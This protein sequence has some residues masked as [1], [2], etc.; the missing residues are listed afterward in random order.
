M[1]IILLSTA[2]TL[3]LLTSLQDVNEGRRNL[4]ALRVAIEGDSVKFKIN[5]SGWSPPLGQLDP[6]SEEA[7]KRRRAE[8]DA[9]NEAN[10]KEW[11]ESHATDNSS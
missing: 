1:H 5:Q 2:E 11:E 9:M 6:Q 4:Y 3:N 7:H 8:I 10:R